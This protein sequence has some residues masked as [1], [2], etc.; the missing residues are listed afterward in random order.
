MNKLLFGVSA[1]LIF[2]FWP[3]SFYLAN[4]QV[5]LVFAASTLVIVLNW[6]LY[7]QKVKYHYFIYLILPLLHPVFLFVPII[8]IIFHLKG[9][10]SKTLAAYAGILM[11][12]ILLT[13][14]S[15]YAYSIFTPDPL[16]KDTLIK[17]IS[18]ISARN[19]AR[20]YENRFTI[21]LEKFKS[22]IF[23]SLDINNYFFAYHPQE[24]GSSQNL[25]KFS[26]LTIMLFIFGIYY[27]NENIHK[28]WLLSTIFSSIVSL[29]LI[30]NQDRY[31]SLLYV[32]VSL[33]CFYGLKKIVTS[34]NYLSKFFM[35][36]Y[37]L[38]SLTEL[39]RVTII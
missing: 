17:K 1:F 10:S 4:R 18:L 11:L 14:K 7:T 35:V 33:V 24:L 32:P 5:W 16:A 3:I 28:K 25:I 8:S 29:A 34:N 21:P 36:I 6:V 19:L 20:V 13:F 30:N 27:L 12:L 39:I 31:E 37:I 38:I 23:E 26:Y 22:N 2:V 15:F 9:I